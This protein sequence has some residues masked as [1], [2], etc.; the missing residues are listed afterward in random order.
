VVRREETITSWDITAD[1]SAK[2][3][4]SDDQARRTICVFH[5]DIA[6]KD[7][8]PFIDGKQRFDYVTHQS[9]ASNL[10]VDCKPTRQERMALEDLNNWYFQGNNVSLTVTM[11]CGKEK[12]DAKQPHAYLLPI[13]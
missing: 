11:R 8:T 1:F 4:I 13:R 10:N 5:R 9:S 7:W 3:Q 12:G 6:A 2:P